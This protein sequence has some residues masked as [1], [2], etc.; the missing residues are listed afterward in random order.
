MVWKPEMCS[1]FTKSQFILLHIGNA[2]SVC[3][4]VQLKAWDLE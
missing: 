4:H 3:Q 1:A 2:L